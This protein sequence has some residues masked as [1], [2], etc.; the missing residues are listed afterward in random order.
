MMK[1]LALDYA[2][3]VGGSIVKYL[4]FDINP[5]FPGWAPKAVEGWQ[6]ESMM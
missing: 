6:T 3:G 1:F 5:P 2:H 4:E